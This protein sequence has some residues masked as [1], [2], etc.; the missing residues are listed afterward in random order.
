MMANLEASLRG[1]VSAMRNMPELIKR[2]NKMVYEASSASR[3]ATFFYAEYDPQSRQVTYVNAGQ[4][5]PVILRE[6]ANTW[7]VFRWEVGGT[8][9]GLLPETDY[10]E[11][12]FD[13]RHSDL[14]VLFT[15][16]VSESM[17]SQDE[18]WEEERMIACAK[19]CSGLSAR[20][21]LNRIMDEAVAFAAGAAQHDDMTLVVLMIK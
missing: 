2:V 9:V 21:T 4:S 12:V 5:P 10:S 15:D 7:E 14:V 11:A 16:G 6:S 20:E 18:E 19:T 8:V 1:Q 13:L 17:N 3:Y